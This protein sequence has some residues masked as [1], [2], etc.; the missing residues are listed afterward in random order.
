MKEKQKD[1]VVKFFYDLVKIIFAVTVIG[2]IA[3]PEQFSILKFIIGLVV[4][5]MLF[6]FAYRL[7]KKEI[8]EIK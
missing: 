2:P 1:N 4:S 8:K 3:Q 7:D 6:I 5:A